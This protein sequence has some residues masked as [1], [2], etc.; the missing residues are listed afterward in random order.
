MGPSC[1]VKV[2]SG[3]CSTRQGGETRTVSKQCVVRLRSKTSERSEGCDTSNNCFRC[4]ACQ[5]STRCL[6]DCYRNN[7]SRYC[8]DIKDQ[9]LKLTVPAVPTALP[10]IFNDNTRTSS[11]N[12]LQ[13]RTIT[14]ESWS[15]DIIV[16]CDS[17]VSIETRCC[18]VAMRALLAVEQC[19]QW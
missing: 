14:D 10:L 16:D 11:N 2:L 3:V 5:G 15:S 18:A 13:L 12:I 7:T 6:I 19:Q 1:C 17:S 9:S 4:N 8:A